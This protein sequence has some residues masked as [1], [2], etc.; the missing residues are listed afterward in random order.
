MT[1]QL[2]TPRRTQLA[3]VVCLVALLTIAACGSDK[4]ESK[5]SASTSGPR[6]SFTAPTN[7]A[8]AKSPVAVTMTAS[9]FT[10]EPAGDVHTGAGHFHVM[11][12][13]GCV[14]AGTPIPKDDSHVH[15]GKAQLS[16]ELVLSPGPHKLCLQLGDGA[17]TALGIT[18]EISITVSS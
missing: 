11:V 5:S 2:M 3:A 1:Q 10:I 15:L 12:D 18:D 4:V 14:A 6:I 8:T 17:H 13:V 9:N 7:G 16:T